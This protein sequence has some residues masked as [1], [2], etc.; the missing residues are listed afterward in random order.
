MK[1][2]T[3]QVK[4]SGEVWL[5]ID[6]TNGCKA[7]INLGF[8]PPESIVQ[9]ALIAAYEEQNNQKGIVPSPDQMQI[10][11]LDEIKQTLDPS[12]IDPLLNAWLNDCPSGYLLEKYKETGCQ[13]P[14]F[15]I[16]QRYD[17]EKDEYGRTPWNR[18]RMR[19]DIS[20]V[21][22]GLERPEEEIGLCECN[23]PVRGPERNGNPDKFYCTTCKK[24][25]HRD[26]L[27]PEEQLI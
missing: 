20:P 1:T 10:P 11:L 25:F 4:P 17:K 16:G 27:P 18:M 7:S 19:M 12:E 24:I 26:Q 9:R 2:L 22:F 14:S 23:K 5:H 8:R 13:L 6:P 3:L 21:H 15:R